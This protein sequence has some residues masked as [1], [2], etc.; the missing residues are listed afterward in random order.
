MKRMAYPCSPGMDFSGIII[1]CPD[2]CCP[3]IMK[4]YRTGKRNLF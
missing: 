1:S 3:S 4:K 2:A